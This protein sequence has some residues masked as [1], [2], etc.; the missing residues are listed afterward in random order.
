MKANRQFSDALHVVAHLVGQDGPRT[1]E[2]LAA[3]LPTHPVVIRR[4]LAALHRAGLVATVRG[5]GGGSQ[6]ARDPASISLY[7]VYVAVGAPPL[8]QVGARH[9][10]PGCPVQQAVDAALNESYQHAQSLLEQRLRATHLATLGAAFARHLADHAHPTR[11]V[12]HD[13]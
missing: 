13:L 5:H 9:T 2:Q 8:L 7:D 6:L 4:L 10:G 12:P 11:G 1:S 3:C